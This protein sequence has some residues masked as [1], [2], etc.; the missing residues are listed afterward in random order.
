MDDLESDRFDALWYKP[1]YQCKDKSA[2]D[3][4]NRIM[5]NA[6]FIGISEH[7]NPN[8]IR[9]EGYGSIASTSGKFICPVQ[10]FYKKENWHLVESVPSS[11][12]C[13]DTPPYPDDWEGE[14]PPPNPGFD[15]K[16]ADDT[17]N[18]CCVDTYIHDEY[19]EEVVDSRPWAAGRFQSN[20][21]ITKH[22]CVVVTELP[23]SASLTWIDCTEDETKYKD[24]KLNHD[25]T[26]KIQGTSA[27]ARGVKSL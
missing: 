16:S 17:S 22:I 5:T 25:G 10:L 20:T 1:H 14:H 7:V 3:F 4:I 19:A 26:S 15:C 11:S 24:C 13:I 23:H 21:D 8:P 27:L 12:Q 2:A 6:D 9:V 18:E